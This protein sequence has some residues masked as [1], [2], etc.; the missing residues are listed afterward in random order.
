MLAPLKQLFMKKNFI[1]LLLHKFYQRFFK[2]QRPAEPF[3]EVIKTSPEQAR[4]QLPERI[5]NKLHELL[6]GKEEHQPGYHPGVHLMLNHT[7]AN[8]NLQ[9]A[10][11]LA[12][13]Q[14]Q[15]LYRVSL[16]GVVSDYIG[17][18][19]KN[20]DKVFYKAANNNLVLLFDEADAL[21]GKRTDVKDAHDKYANLEIAYLQ[22]SIRAFRDT[23]LF[24]CVTQDCRQWQPSDFI[25]IAE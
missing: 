2:I 15:N 25:K 16:S 1:F 8:V 19:E 20:L 9:T 6:N 14:Q 18:T 5:K 21:F 13:Q 24:N 23:V 3:E 10:Q 12:A 7:D 11:W 22:K 4:L 17:E